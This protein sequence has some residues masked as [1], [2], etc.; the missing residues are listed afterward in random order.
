MTD[1]TPQRP[2]PPGQYGGR[3]DDYYPTARPHPP[4]PPPRHNA[5]RVKRMMDCGAQTNMFPA[6]ETAKDAAHAVASTRYP[7]G[8]NNGIRGISSVVR[9]GTYGLDRSYTSTANAQ[10]SVIVQVES[11]TG[12]ANISAIAATDGV[13]CIFFG[14][15]DFAA[16]MG[17]LGNA[18]H[19]DVQTAMAYITAVC[20][21]HG[22]AVGVYAPDADVARR[23]RDMGINFISLHSDIVW[24]TRGASAA[25][26]AMR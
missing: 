19:N 10:A 6:I 25:V 3:P 26:G 11:P 21:Q 4:P 7:Q 12:F 13:D 1:N 14:T 17:H 16:N 22:K 24:L 2:Q 5:A 18:S 9:A 15:A 20:Q 8:N 23:Y